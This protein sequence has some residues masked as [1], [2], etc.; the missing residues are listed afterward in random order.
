MTKFG[1]E[2]VVF[3]IL[4]KSPTV[5]FRQF[6]DFLTEFHQALPHAW[7]DVTDDS[8]SLMAY[9]YNQYLHITNDT[10]TLVSGTTVQTIQELTSRSFDWMY[11]EDENKK[12]EDIASRIVSAC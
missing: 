12:A 5:T 1:T 2:Y 3:K 11:T 9:Q 7:L 8:I 6:N 10:F 4:S